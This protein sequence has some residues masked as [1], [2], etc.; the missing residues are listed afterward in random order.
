MAIKEAKKE[1]TERS[2]Y[3]H[4]PFYSNNPSM[5]TIQN[6]WRKHVAAPAGE[7]P[8]NIMSNNLGAAIPVDQLPITFHRHRAPNLGNLLSYRKIAHR[9]RSNVSSSIED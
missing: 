8:L 9:T 5:S 2:M 7:F 1:A 6:L 4:V 3:L